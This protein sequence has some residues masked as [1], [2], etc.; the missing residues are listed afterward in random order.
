MSASDIQGDAQHSFCDAPQQSLIWALL[1]SSRG[2]YTNPHPFQ[3]LSINML[4]HFNRES[5]IPDY[6]KK[7]SHY[8]ASLLRWNC[9]V[10]T[11]MAGF[12]EVGTDIAELIHCQCLLM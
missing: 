12:T 9:I 6:V 7:F 3:I 8:L 2:S 4:A 1:L 10:L 5:S 11:M